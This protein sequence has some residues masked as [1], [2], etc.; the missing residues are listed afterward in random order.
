MASTTQP[1]LSSQT[2]NALSFCGNCT[3]SNELD[4]T[5]ESTKLNLTA[6][7]TVEALDLSWVIV[8]IS[9][10]AGPNQQD[11]ANWRLVSSPLWSV[12]FEVTWHVCVCVRAPGPPSCVLLFVIVS[13]A[14]ACASLRRL[15]PVSRALRALA[16]LNRARG[17]H[18][19]TL[20]GH[21]TRDAATG[22][23]SAVLDH[24]K[25]GATGDDQRDHQPP[26]SSTTSHC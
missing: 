1:A 24:S 5:V 16:E 14:H 6:G 2:I 18:S 9:F 15:R 7:E 13:A 8:G 20:S 10:G 4:S 17:V 25:D 12:L 23:H 21:K 3:V 22:T 11:M 19:A 26:C